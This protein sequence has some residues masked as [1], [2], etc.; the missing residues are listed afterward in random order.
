MDTWIVSGPGRQIAALSQALQ[1]QGVE[2]RVF[3]FQRTGRPTSPFIAYLERAGVPHVVIPDNG[4]LD[5]SL[6]R[7][8]RRVFGDWKPDIVQSHGYRMTALV[9][10][11]KLMRCRLPWVA[12]FHG[13]THENWKMR[14]YNRLDQVLMRRADRIVVLSQEHRRGFADVADR[15]RL[16]HNASIPLPPE[17]E[18]IQLDHIRQ[19]GKPIIAALARLSPE[20]GVDLLIEATARL[21]ASGRPVS[22]VVAGDGP[23]RDNLARR[24]DCLGIGDSVHF[25]GSVQNVLSL[26]AK[27]DVVVLPSRCGAEG[28]P[29]VLLEAMRA[30]VPV[31]ATAVAAVP[32]VLSDPRSGELVL[33]GD[34]EAL[35]RGIEAAL[36]RGKTPEASAARAAALARFS[37]Q[38]RMAEHLSLYAEMRPDR[39]V[40]PSP[41]QGAI[42]MPTP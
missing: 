26:Y 35:V 20:K 11:L 38:R 3:M 2:L 19:A 39:L 5:A 18:E 13:A 41:T 9:F 10:A 6:P 4:T 33:P 16:I 12:F 8:L 28:L 17:G 1:A 27:V 24:A 34:I 32:E 21:A 40:Q 30:D 23:E 15:V 36:G 42:P 25:L 31:V 7:H 22:L 29:N 37:L 14:L